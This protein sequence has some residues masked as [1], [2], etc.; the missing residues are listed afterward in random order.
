MDAPPT[1]DV[2]GDKATFYDN[3]GSRSWED[4]S[5]SS[6]L[7]EHTI[8]YELRYID[9]PKIPIRRRHFT[10]DMSVLGIQFVATMEIFKRN[11]VQRAFRRDQFN[12]T[13]QQSY[14][15]VHLHTVPDMSISDLYSS[16]ALEMPCFFHSIVAIFPVL[17]GAWE[18]IVE[19]K[20]LEDLIYACKF[21]LSA[22][23]TEPSNLPPGMVAR[24]A[25]VS[26]AMA[27]A[28]VDPFAKVIPRI[29]LA[30]VQKYSWNRIMKDTAE[31]FTVQRPQNMVV[32]DRLYIIHFGG[33]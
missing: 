29:Y 26:W 18:M 33:Q 22:R 10:S 23:A 5:R 32:G 7:T 21:A 25:Q 9:L 28:G 6:T 12:K 15:V 24:A 31:S 4:L 19:A 13:L 17:P 27:R 8:Q 2:D 11:I 16:L 14:R 30:L 20:H 1:V 3:D